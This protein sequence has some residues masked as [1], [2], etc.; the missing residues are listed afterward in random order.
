MGKCV[1]L[2][3]VLLVLAGFNGTANATK[4]LA[5]ITV[6]DATYAGYTIASVDAN[7]PDSLVFV[8]CYTPDFEG[9][10]V[11]AAYFVVID[12]QAT[13]GPLWSTLWY[14]SSADCVATHGWFSARGFGEWKVIASTTF[15]VDGSS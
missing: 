13:V 8:Q 6:A 2:A 7:H 12:K 4:P 11:Y 9:T 3:T 14:P 1:L 5:G 10:Y 15:H